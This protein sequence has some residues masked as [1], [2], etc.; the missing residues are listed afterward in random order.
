M[1]GESGGVFIFTWE[2]EREKEIKGAKISR[3]WLRKNE[4]EF[5]SNRKT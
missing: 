2:R 5:I 3:P 1:C 4:L